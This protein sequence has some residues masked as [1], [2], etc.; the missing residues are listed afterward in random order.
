MAL[1]GPPSMSTPVAATSRGVENDC[2]FL[3]PHPLVFLH[4]A[5][6]SPTSPAGAFKAYHKMWQGYDSD[7][8][9]QEWETA[10]NDPSV[11]RERNDKNELTLAVKDFTRYVGQEGCEKANHLKRTQAVAPGQIASAERRVK[12]RLALTDKFIAETG[13]G[14]HDRGHMALGVSGEDAGIS[15]D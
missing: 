11:H 14:M 7:E 9:E 3:P 1:V 12:G 10:S 2:S 5:P 4:L 13:G 6:P 8:A 15:D